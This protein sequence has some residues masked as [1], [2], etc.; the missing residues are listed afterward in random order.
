[1]IHSWERKNKGEEEGG[2][3][4]GGEAKGKEIVFKACKRARY[5]KDYAFDM[6]LHAISPTVSNP[7]VTLP[8][9]GET[10]SIPNPHKDSLRNANHKTRFFLS[11]IRLQ[12]PREL[13]F[14]HDSP[15]LQPPPLF[16][17]DL[18]Q[19]RRHRQR[20]A[21]APPPHRMLLLLQRRGVPIELPRALLR[22]EQEPET[23]GAAQDFLEFLAAFLAAAAVLLL[24]SGGGGRGGGRGGKRAQDGIEGVQGGG[25]VGVAGVVGGEGCFVAVF[26]L[27]EAGG[28]GAPAAHEGHASYAGLK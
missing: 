23:C 25:D 10:L 27:Q 20:P 15:P 4:R 24:F 18:H 3:G 1:M 13:L 8:S 26:G 12:P 16:I 21:A 7:L 6:K 17:P 28:E 14:L 5:E 9:P 11:K 19:R 22:E 2:E